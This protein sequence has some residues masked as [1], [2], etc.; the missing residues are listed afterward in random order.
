MADEFGDKT[1]AATPRKREEARE[2]GQVARSTDLSAA[3]VLV[4]AMLMLG[5]F[6]PMVSEALKGVMQESLSLR[7]IADHTPGAA[8]T[9][10]LRAL[11]VAGLAS[12]PLVLGLMAAAMIGNVIQ[13][14]FHPTPTRLQPK[15][16]AISP[17]KGIKRLFG[18]VQTIVQLLMNLLKLSVV[19]FIGYTAV[20]GRLGEIVASQRM[21]PVQAFGLA[22]GLVY[23][24]GLRVAVAL[25]VLAIIDYVWKRFKHERDLRMTKQEV[26][27]EM[28]RMEGDPMI[29][30][31]RR[32][33]AMQMSR[34][35][36][37]RAVPSADV[38]VTNPTEYAVALKY[39]AGSGG[40]PKVVA[41]G[42]G[43]IAAEIRR[44]AIENGVPILE[45]PPL[46]RAL[47]RL[48]PVGAE[49]PE[50]FYAAVAEILAYVYE[51]TGK[52]RNGRAMA[53]V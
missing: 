27:D 32:Q 33:I 15:L 2:R 1:E 4:F 47:Y 11:V 43:L 26:K 12:A 21:E 23:D 34:D 20:H 19:G 51:L 45:R 36:Q 14:G 3:V 44:I 22:A 31:R 35:R 49:I 52:I 7:V 46:A 41:K 8:G 24:V 13:V 42:R 30:A 28:K 10:A 25:L 39:E 17:L 29:K 18:D 40:A 38:V 48:V 16:S 50:E 37:K 53:G 6:G 9:L 5:W